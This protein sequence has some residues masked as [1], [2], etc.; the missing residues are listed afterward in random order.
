MMTTALA[1]IVGETSRDLCYAVRMLIQ[2]PVFAIVAIASIALSVGANALV[3][4]VVNGLVL[5]PLPVSDPGR[6]VFVE[7]EGWFPAHSFPAYRDMRDRNV[8]LEGM[9]G[10]RITTMD[11]EAEGNVTR[12]WGYLATGNYFDMLGVVPAAGRLLHQAG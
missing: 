3:L 9:A 10:Y 5:K 12:E 6:V 8:T 1:R 2:S 11:V 7:R 4:S